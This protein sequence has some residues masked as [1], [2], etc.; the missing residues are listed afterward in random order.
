VN[1]PIQN[2]SAPATE[3]AYQ[4]L[5]LRRRTPRQAS[6][7]LRA[8]GAAL[9]DNDQGLHIARQMGAALAEECQQPADDSLSSLQANLNAAFAE[10]DLGLVSVSASREALLLEVQEYPAVQL[11]PSHPELVI[12][13]LLEGLLTAYL[14]R[15]SGS[16]DLSARLQAPPSNTMEPLRF[17][18]A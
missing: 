13:G 6:T 7:L 4:N 9:T 15:L 8:L 1:S 2:G 11:A 10:L 17:A 3:S 18:Y 5:T 12:F 14:N 16:R